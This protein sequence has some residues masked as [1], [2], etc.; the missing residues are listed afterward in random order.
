[1]ITIVLG[2]L[3]DVSPLVI[4]PLGFVEAA[5]ITAATAL[6]AERFLF[7]MSQG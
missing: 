7:P 2:P 4:L 6:L 1:M 3:L 5:S